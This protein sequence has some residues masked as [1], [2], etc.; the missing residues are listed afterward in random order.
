M[1]LVLQ[2]SHLCGN[3]S[4][5]HG[6]GIVNKILILLRQ[7]KAKKVV[8][9]IAAGKPTSKQPVGKKIAS[10]TASTDNLPQFKQG[11]LNCIMFLLHGPFH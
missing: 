10:G 3:Y 11:K 9:T 8:S 4:C 1:L 7:L 6:I 5:H 2:K